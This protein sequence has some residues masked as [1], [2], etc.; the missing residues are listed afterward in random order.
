VLGIALST[1][2]ARAVLVSHARVTWSGER[3]IEPDGSLGDAL[4]ELALASGATPARTQLAVAVG[5][6]F[7]QLRQLHGLPRVRD[8]RVLAAIVQQSAGRYF[9]QDG[10][11]MVTTS[12]GDAAGD[13]PWAG[14]IEEPVVEAVAELGR[15]L[16]FAST[17]IVPSAAV[18]G[19]AAPGSAFTWH[20]GDIALELRYDG[21]CLAGCRCLPVRLSAGA[22]GE[23]AVLDEPLARLASD[24]LR[25]ADAY[26]AAAGA[27]ATAVLL[28]PAEAIAEPTT[29]RLAF[30]AAAF[31]LGIAFLIAAPSIASTRAERRA[32]AQLASLATASRRAERMERALAD[33]TR[34]LARLVELQ[35]GATSRT[36]LL[37]ALTC[38][39]DDETTLVSLQLEPSGGTLTA[40]TPSPAGLLD[41]LARVPRIA[42]PAIV[43]S[44]TPEAPVS[45]SPVVATPSAVQDAPPT[46]SRVTIHFLWRD[47]HGTRRLAPRCTT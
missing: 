13:A 14:A 20:D 37:G 25:Y 46:P 24:A 5:P 21:V 1:G 16:R 23:G 4:R 43:G 33:D 45:Q 11:P 44:V 35:R 17:T 41:K 26:A 6:G 27:P 34:L 2:A 47:V 31:A 3:A 15:T 19:H 8:Q 39:I 32:T 18:L 12:L 30:A 42:S 28:R 38:A 10:T 29:R 9:R 22:H 7:A 36:L 40:R